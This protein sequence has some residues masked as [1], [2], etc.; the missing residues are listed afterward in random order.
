[1]KGKSIKDLENEINET[2]FQIALRYYWGTEE[3]PIDYSKSFSILEKLYN[4]SSLAEAKYMYANSLY[5]GNG[6]KKNQDKARSVYREILENENTLTD[7]NSKYTYAKIYGLGLGVEENKEKS[8]KYFEECNKVFKKSKDEYSKYKLGLNY[9]YGRGTEKDYRKAADALEKVSSISE[10]YVVLGEIYQYGGNGV[11]KDVKTANKYY[12]IAAE[13][14]NKTG[15][16]EMAV[17]CEKNGDYQK[18]V[19]YYNKV[20]ELD[21]QVY[22][23]NNALGNIYFNGNSEVKRDLEK[24][25]TYFEKLD[26]QFNDGGNYDLMLGKIYL[27]NDYQNHSIQN[28][29]NY[30]EKCANKY[31]SDLYLGLLYYLI[32]EVKDYSKAKSYFESASEESNGEAMNYLADMYFYGYGVE[33]DFGKALELYEKA[34]S[35]FGFCFDVDKRYYDK[36]RIADKVDAI[37]GPDTF[38]KI[39]RMYF[40]GI[41]VNKDWNR[42]LKEFRESELLH[43]N[44]EASFYIGLINYNGGYGVERNYKEA[45]RAFEEAASNNISIANYY[46]GK[47]YYWGDGVEQNTYKAFEY[48][49]K[50]NNKESKTYLLEKHIADDVSYYGNIENLKNRLQSLNANEISF[51]EQVSEESIENAISRYQNIISTLDF[52]DDLSLYLKYKLAGYIFLVDTNK[53]HANYVEGLLWDLYNSNNNFFGKY[54]ATYSLGISYITGSYFESKLERGLELL[55]ESA[56]NGNID[57]VKELVEIYTENEYVEANSEVAG[58]YL[59]QLEQISSVSKVG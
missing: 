54:L 41:G 48:F 17:S 40:E 37:W 3:T 28:A 55:K 23:V 56:E 4:E 49:A 11:S 53:R 45:K 18:A 36:L 14:N 7:T 20:L 24:A 1:M 43:N 42:A 8:D 59:N 26:S 2:L 29:I 44:G 35:C 52:N 33:Q 50:A 19:E 21:Y 47:L 57:A 9:Y 13:N 12:K 5:I 27:S 15:L 38:V 6:V 46:L 10:A 31:F 32:D 16:Y 51:Y 58:K 39:G 30:F 25:K 22:N 34:K